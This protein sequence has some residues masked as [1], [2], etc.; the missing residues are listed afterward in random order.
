M[1]QLSTHIHGLISLPPCFPNCCLMKAFQS[2]AYGIQESSF[3]SQILPSLFYLFLSLRGLCCFLG[4]SLVEVR[5]FS[6]WWLLLLQLQKLKHVGS[7]Q[8]RDQTCVSCI[9]RWILFCGA[10][11]E[12]PSLHLWRWRRT[13]L[14]CLHLA[15]LCLRTWLKPLLGFQSWEDPFTHEKDRCSYAGR[16]TKARMAL[17]SPSWCMRPRAYPGLNENVFEFLQECPYSTADIIS[18]PIIKL[19][20]FFS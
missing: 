6:L 7:S 18:W 2:I 14:M 4:F 11:R 5:S 16:I 1:K 12:A 17:K 15:C 10:S 13:F 19:C 3:C 8:T 9:G 20:I